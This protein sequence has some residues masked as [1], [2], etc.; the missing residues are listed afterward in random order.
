MHLHLKVSLVV[1]VLLAVTYFY[2]G[3]NVRRRFRR[4]VLRVP[5]GNAA[6]RLVIQPAK[7]GVMEMLLPN[8]ALRRLRKGE[9]I[10]GLIQ[11][12]KSSMVFRV[13]AI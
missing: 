4:L 10:E 3:W 7:D 2:G 11:G 13:K 5:T 1:L 6:L 12:Q 9:P 8:A